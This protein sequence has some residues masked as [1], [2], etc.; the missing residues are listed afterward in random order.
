MLFSALYI[1]SR[2]SQDGDQEV[3]ASSDSPSRP[4]FFMRAG[5]ALVA[6]RYHKARP[7]SVEAVLLYAVCK[8]MQKEDSDTD[9]WMI[10]GIS[11]RLAMRMGYHRDPRHLA[12]ISPFEGEMRRRTFF[13]G[14][15]FDLLLSFQAGL[16]SILHEEECDTELPSNLFDTDFDEDCK[17]LPPSRPPTD[18]TPMLYYCCK[19]RLAIICRRIIR[20]ALSLKTLS[21]EETMKLDGELHETHADVPLSLRMKPIGSSFTDQPYMILDRLHIDLLYLKSLCILHR[22]YISHERS[23]PR[24]DYSRKTCIDAALKIL[25]HQAEIYVA[26]QPG[27]QFHNDKWMLSSLALHDFLLAAM[28][29]CLDLYE[30]HNKMATTSPEDLN[31]HARKYDVLKLSHEIWTARRAFSRDARRASN[32]LGVMLSKVSGPNIP[33][34]QGDAP[35]KM[36]IVAQAPLNGEDALSTAA[37]SSENPSWNTTGFDIPDLEVNSDFN[38]ADPLKT[39]L[40]ESDDIDWV[41]RE[42]LI[43]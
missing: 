21:Y 19:S 32:V 26:C 35:Q 36:S 12:N 9:A 20:H 23:N 11:A 14:M 24:Y 31:D 37:N 41:S 16:P 7:Y 39:I 42:Y 25:Q 33:S 43:C 17:A 18:P 1:G 28:I 27:G 3:I 5:Q 10:M 38:L 40:G 15:T 29:T 2:I 22:K 4:T 34:S 8:Y 13:I 30:S 6:G